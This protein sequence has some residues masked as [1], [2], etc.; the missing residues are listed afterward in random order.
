MPVVLTI[1]L[2]VLQKLRNN[3]NLR[4]PIFAIASLTLYYMIYFEWYLPKVNSRYTAD[5]I[6][7]ILYALGAIIFYLMQN[8]WIKKQPKH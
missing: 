3:L 8:K 5:F 6:D 4:I 2:V 7:V 1:C